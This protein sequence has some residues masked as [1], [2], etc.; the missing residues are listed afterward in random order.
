MRLF[1]VEGDLRLRN[2]MAYSVPWHEYGIELSGLASSGSEALH[3]LMR[4]GADI[5]LTDIRIPGMDGLALSAKLLAERPSLKVIVISRSDSIECARQAIGIGVYQL[6]LK[7]AGD[8]E[9][10]EAVVSAAEA[11][12]RELEALHRQ[13]EM[14][15]RWREHLP[16]L[17]QSF[18]QNWISGRFTDWEIV[19]RSRKLMIET[20]DDDKYAVVVADMDPLPTDESRYSADDGSLLKFS[21]HS[22][23][24]ELQSGLDSVTGVFQDVRD[25]T[26]LLYVSPAEETE[27]DFYAR[28][29]LSVSKLLEATRQCLKLT[30]TAG[31]GACAHH[32]EQVGRS[33]Q[34]ALQAL[35]ERIVHGHDI[36][37][38]FRS[39]TAGSKEKL[40]ETEE[41]RLL[42]SALETGNEEGA[43]EVYDRFLERGLYP[44][45]G[46]A[47]IQETVLHLCS[48]FVRMIHLRGW[49]LRAVVGDDYQVFLHPDTLQTKEQVAKLFRRTISNMIRYANETALTETQ[50]LIEDI[51][52]YIEEEIKEDLNLK[53][54]A[55]KYYMN[56]SYLSRIFKQT[57]GEAFS[58]YLLKRKMEHARRMLHDGFKVYDVANLLGYAD[59]SYFIRL[60]Q[61]FWGVTPGKFKK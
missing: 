25:L 22:I 59:V 37:I 18:Y 60:F 38:P 5:V 17:Q 4:V 48:V 53:M 54:V 8:D 36:V 23:A 19:E 24:S 27:A 52:L 58:T 10:I 11:A 21:L 13:E 43:M 7:P 57:T 29:N 28:I 39:H 34:Q 42:K 1:I 49:S 61:K 16:R 35:R 14:E 41:L 20:R 2:R 12:R 30:A 3:Q 32:K 33:Y 31:V 46:L 26:V 40:L 6:L 9:L 15:A 47:A 51:L 50:Q 44:V 45:T 56:P 55:D